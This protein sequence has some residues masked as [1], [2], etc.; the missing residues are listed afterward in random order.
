MSRGVGESVDLVV[1]TGI[2]TRGKEGHGEG[3]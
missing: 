1:I 2:S 3:G